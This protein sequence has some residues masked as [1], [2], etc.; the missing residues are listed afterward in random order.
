MTFREGG[1]YDYHTTFEQIKERLHHAV[2][3]ARDQGQNVNSTSVLNTSDLSRIDLEQLPAYEPPPEALNSQP[4]HQQGPPSP[5]H[6]IARD[7]GVSG[8][9]PESSPK[10]E[11][12]V[13]TP[14]NEPPPG[15]E[16]AYVQAVDIDL[17]Q[18]LREEAER[19]RSESP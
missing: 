7:S 8:V 16:E 17:D 6:T 4:T 11:G 3:L 9:R 15:Y 5:D 2:Q 18:R 19:Q 12:E 13:F 10:E 14:P 1:A